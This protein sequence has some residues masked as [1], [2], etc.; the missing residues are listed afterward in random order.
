MSLNENISGR[1]LR[2]GPEEPFF[3]TAKDLEG[4]F[5]S[6]TEPPEYMYLLQFSPGNQKPDG[7]YHPLKVIVDKEKLKVL[8]RAGYFAQKPPNSRNH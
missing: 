7:K 3:I 6:L 2:T 4:G 5:R 1:T 8:A